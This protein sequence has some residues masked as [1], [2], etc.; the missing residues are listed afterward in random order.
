MS[1]HTC[2]QL[3]LLSCALNVA[4]GRVRSRA[5]A[6]VR[7][8]ERVNSHM[9]NQSCFKKLEGRSASS[10]APKCRKDCGV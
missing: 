6:C 4:R 8:C 7:F 10:P 9:R 3:Q 2:W 5:V 1:L